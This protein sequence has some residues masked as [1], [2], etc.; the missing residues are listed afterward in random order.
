MAEP[1][2]T[3]TVGT[4]ES[5]AEATGVNHVSSL[6]RGLACQLSSQA[7]GPV[8]ILEEETL[9]SLLSGPEAPE[10]SNPEGRC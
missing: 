3:L 10:F 4:S 2:D 9:F 7:G 6:L 1:K 5:G 8:G